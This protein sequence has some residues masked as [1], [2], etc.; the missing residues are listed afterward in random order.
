MRL[1]E[2]VRL[3]VKD[4]DFARGETVIRDGKAGLERVNL[5]GTV[6]FEI[7]AICLCRSR[8]RLL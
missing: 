5:I 7:T 6:N 8:T 3:C 1:M 4:V 2:C